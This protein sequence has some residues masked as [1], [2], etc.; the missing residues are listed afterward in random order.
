SH[1][2]D[3]GLDVLS[4]G[5]REKLHP[6]HFLQAG[7][8]EAEVVGVDG[9]VRAVGD[10]QLRLARWVVRTGARADAERHRRSEI[11][12]ATYVRPS[13][14]G[15]LLRLGPD[16]ALLVRRIERSR[17]GSLRFFAGALPLPIRALLLRLGLLFL[18]IRCLRLRI[19]YLLRLSLRQ[20]VGLGLDGIGCGIVERILPPGRRRYGRNPESQRDRPKPWQG[21]VDQ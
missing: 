19:R 17:S 8:G 1:P 12:A 3:R 15:V 18:P 10:L 21:P 6:V 20:R 2:A 9:P 5:V 7:V 13:L 4:L 16:R 11:A 14:F